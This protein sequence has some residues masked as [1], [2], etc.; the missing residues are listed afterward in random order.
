MASTKDKITRAVA[1][2]ARSWVTFPPRSNAVNP[3]KLLASLNRQQSMAFA[4]AFL[5]WTLDGMDFFMVSMNL[6]DIAKEFDVSVSKLSWSITITLMLRPVGALLFG[7]AAD[8]WGRRWPLMVDII[9][10]SAFEL[11]TGFT[12][13]YTQFFLM[14]LFFGIAMGGEWG[15]GAALAMESLPQD[16]RGIFSGILQEGYSLGYLLAAVIYLGRDTIGW[17]GMFWIGCCPALLTIFIR[18]FVEESHTYEIS[19]EQ[20]K[21]KNVAFIKEIWLLVKK[22]YLLLFYGICLMSAFNFMSHGSQDLYPTFLQSPPLNLSPGRTTV[23]AVV[24]NCGAIIGGIIFGYISQIFGRRRTIIVAACCGA[25]FIPLWASTSL[26]YG[27]VLMGS[28]FLQ[29]FV[30]GAWGVIPVHINEL[31]PAGFRGTFPGLLYQ[32]GNL[33]SSA[34]STIQSDMAAKNPTADGNPDYSKVQMIFMG[35][36]FAAVVFFTF[37]GP[38]ECGVDLDEKE[39]IGVEGER[40]SGT[41]LVIGAPSGEKALESGPGDFIV[42]K[43]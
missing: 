34:A 30:Q 7:L 25:C 42:A 32:C 12:Q 28:F 9:M 37:I 5:G 10:F 1:S 33:V 19:K 3:F 36:I 18:F 16:A 39:I 26:P 27:G 4:A 31:S 24:Y 22:H 13:N 21:S 14:R 6:K 35:S 11:G 20:R 23:T 38:E 43:A 2:W 29:L 15:L 40:R 41:D 17:R 8:K